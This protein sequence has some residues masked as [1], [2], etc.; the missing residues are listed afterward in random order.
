MNS[1]GICFLPDVVTRY[2]VKFSIRST[3]HDVIKLS[4][5]FF[6][7]CI[8]LAKLLLKLGLFSFDGDGCCGGERSNGAWLGARFGVH[9]SN[10]D[11][12]NAFNDCCNH[13]AG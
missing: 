2:N 11:S 9:K 3:T 13:S 8:C 5:I 7:D 12:R 10:K 4:I 1:F 6:V